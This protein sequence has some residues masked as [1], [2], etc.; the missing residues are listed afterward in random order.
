MLPAAGRIIRPAVHLVQLTMLD[1]TGKLARLKHMR[2]RVL[3]CYPAM[4]D[5]RSGLARYA[6]PALVSVAASHALAWLHHPPFP[7]K[8]GGTAF[9]GPIRQ[10]S[11]RD[12]RHFRLWARYHVVP[13][14]PHAR[15]PD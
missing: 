3:A 13:V 6:R 4:D 5:V 11:K 12:I 2:L 14:Y 8:A 1:D 7:L 15:R 9:R 10:V